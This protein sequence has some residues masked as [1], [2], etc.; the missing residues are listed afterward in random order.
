MDDDV[1]E[2]PSGGQES[3]HNAGAASGWREAGHA[4]GH[5]P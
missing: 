3:T 2:N 5:V 1:E 4:V